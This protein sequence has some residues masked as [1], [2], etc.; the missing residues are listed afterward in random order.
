[1]PVAQ[2]K[3]ETT[4]ARIFADVSSRTTTA[5]PPLDIAAFEALGR[6]VV[7]ARHERLGELGP[8]LQPA[9]QRIHEVTGPIGE[10]DGVEREPRAGG[11]I[12]A[13][14]SIQPPVTAEVLLHR[15]LPI[16]G[17]CLEHDTEPR[18]YL[19]RPLG[20]VDPEYTHGAARRPAT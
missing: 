6:N 12:R 4:T 9:G 7:R 1:M 17:W 11:E 16:D 19:V 5:Y 10:S 2:S 14:K 15:Q 13:V 8:P 20:N 18:A 3:V